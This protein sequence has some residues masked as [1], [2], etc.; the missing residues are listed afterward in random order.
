MYFYDMEWE[1]YLENI[2]HFSDQRG[3]LN[4][5]LYLKHSAIIKANYVT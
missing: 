1:L 4:L 2:C 3:N 5:K